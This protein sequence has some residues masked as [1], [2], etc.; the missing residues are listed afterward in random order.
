MVNE[1]FT[2][3]DL[4]LTKENSTIV[5]IP[6]KFDG[7][8]FID[9]FIHL[10]VRGV[11]NGPLDVRLYWIDSPLSNGPVDTL[12][13]QDT[14]LE[15][16]NYYRVVFENPTI[17]IYDSLKYLNRSISFHQNRNLIAVHFPE[18][19]Q[20]ISSGLE[21]FPSVYFS[22]NFSLAEVDFPKLSSVYGYFYFNDNRKL[23][24]INAPELSIVGKYIYIDRNP[25]LQSINIK[26]LSFDGDYSSITNEYNICQFIDNSLLLG[27]H[28]SCKRIV[29]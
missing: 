16:I 26:G 17:I 23:A 14:S 27:K 22:G 6:A 20:V 19:S 28:H 25:N 1:S 29:I 2:E 24:R 21:A 3:Y 15:E 13:I 8:G 5:E 11:D 9:L 7:S 18:L 12:R 4:Q 10:V